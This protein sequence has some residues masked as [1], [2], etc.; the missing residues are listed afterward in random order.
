MN[1]C[2]VGLLIYSDADALLDGFVTLA[3]FR[4]WGRGTDGTVDAL[5]A[6]WYDTHRCL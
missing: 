6:V 2:E 3:I 5:D 1:G 4:F